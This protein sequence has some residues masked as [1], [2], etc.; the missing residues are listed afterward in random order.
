MLKVFLIGWVVLLAAIILNVVVQRLGLMGWYDFLSQLSN[1]GKT[2][3]LQMRIIDCAWLF[4]VYP[5]LL[6]GAAQVGAYLHAL[7]TGK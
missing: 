4:V 7:L 2:V 5:L 6:G 3:L 1:E